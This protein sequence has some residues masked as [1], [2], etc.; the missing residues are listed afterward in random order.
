MEVE[1]L[2]KLNS[3]LLLHRHHAIFSPPWWVCMGFNVFWGPTGHFSRA[4]K[5]LAVLRAPTF[6]TP[7]PISLSRA[8]ETQVLQFSGPG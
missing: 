8:Q 1:R 7:F 5:A 4:T 3:N 2:S 6:P